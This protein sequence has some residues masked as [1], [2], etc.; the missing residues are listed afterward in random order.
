[1]LINRRLFPLSIFIRS[2]RA[3]IEWLFKSA[4]LRVRKRHNDN[5]NDNRFGRE[6][7]ATDIIVILTP[8]KMNLLLPCKSKRSLLRQFYKQRKFMREMA[9]SADDDDVANRRE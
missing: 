8:F 5:D 2:F 4:L 3:E 6:R 1:M 7:A 9:R